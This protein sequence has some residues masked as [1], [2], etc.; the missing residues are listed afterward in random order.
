MLEPERRQLLLEALRPPPGF[1]FDAAVGTTFTLDLVALLV[2][3]IAFAMFDVEAEDGRALANPI[4]VLEA[5]RRHAG[6]V[7]VFAQAGE[8]KVPPAVR[9]AY[10]YLERSVVPVQPPRAEGIF[11]PK[12]WC[13]RYRSPDGETA[14][15]FLCLSRNLTLDR[16]WD[17]VLRLDGRPTATA[18]TLSKPL[19]DFVRA[20]P[21]LA[22]RPVSND[23]RALVDVIAEE[24]STCTWEPLPDG[25]D[26]KG[27][28]PMGH[29]GNESWPF[30]HDSWRRLIVAPFV[31][32]DF[33]ERFTKKGRRD[34]LVSRESTIEQLGKPPLS[35]LGH[36]WV[37]RPEAEADPASIDA[38]AAPADQ[39]I[40]TSAPELRGL[41]AKL[42][43]MNDPYRARIW[44]GSANATIQA[45]TQNVEFLVHLDGTNRLHSPEVLTASEG[46]PSVGFGKL[47]MEYTPPDEAQPPD[48]KEEATFAL[49]AIARELGGIKFEAKADA[50]EGDRWRLNLQAEAALPA[51]LNE[52]SIHLRPVSLGAGAAVEP[53]RMKAGFEA[54]WIVSFAGLTEFFVIDL[55]S[56][57]GGDAVKVSF[58]VTA[59]LVGGPADR[60]ERILAGE[61]KN[62]SALLRLLLLLLGNLDAA[63]GDLVEIVSGEP[64]GGSWGEVNVL[65][66][67]AL[68]EPLMRTLARDPNRLDDI[69]RLVAELSKTEA[70]RDLLPPGWASLWTSVSAARPSK[71][72]NR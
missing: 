50:L 35:H 56:S 39:R 69:E 2:T 58:I 30:P 42:F 15:R 38:D 66:S 31:K 33:L 24:I 65:G 25:L 34:Y 72:A 41:H 7:T 23:R 10:A 67:D 20:L 4:A 9:G 18:R 37:L 44:T 8:I 32:E 64:T 62:R 61:I 40:E 28:V 5:V 52:T 17:T 36:V 27:F 1:V 47:L 59:P 19:G 71:A 13:I 68:L 21:G 45:F 26:L 3:P 53:R 29:D 49:D 46:G 22:V 6:R 70:G 57:S 12:V 43:V 11:H 55:E 51:S 14:Y 48:P 54:E 63:F 16:A 60:L